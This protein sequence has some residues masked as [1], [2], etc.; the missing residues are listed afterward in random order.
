MNLVELTEY[1]VKNLVKNEDSVKVS[2]LDEEENLITIQVLVSNDDMGRV[3]GKSGM[4]AKAIR[5]LVQ[6]SSN[7][8]E[9]PKVKIDIDGF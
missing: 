4:I 1:I 8:N 2:L 6:A 7:I 5:T 3:I 9:G